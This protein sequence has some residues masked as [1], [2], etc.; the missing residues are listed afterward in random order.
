MIHVRLCV[1]ATGYRPADV[2]YLLDMVRLKRAATGT[3]AVW[4][5]CHLT[6]LAGAREYANH[7]GLVDDVLDSTGV[8]ETAGGP[9]VTFVPSALEELANRKPGEQYVFVLVDHGTPKYFGCNHVTISR[10]D[11]LILSKQTRDDNIILISCGSWDLLPAAITER[12]SSLNWQG[13]IP[14]RGSQFFLGTVG[15]RFLLQ[16]RGVVDPFSR[17]VPHSAFNPSL[18]P[19]WPAVLQVAGDNI[20]DPDVPGTLTHS[21]A[22]VIRT[23][24]RTKGDVV[25]NLVAMWQEHVDKGTVDAEAFRENWEELS[26][27][28]Y[29]TEDRTGIPDL[30]HVALAGEMSTLMQIARA[31]V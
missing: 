19:A 23:M 16:G 21:L 1:I 17:P 24:P 22:A 25:V 3:F 18:L 29:V 12:Y 7:L 20:D 26:K 10:D 4:G 9:P 8:L 27:L 28:G 6:N 30:V 5:A 14:D 13:A 2:G 15:V 31:R 11:L